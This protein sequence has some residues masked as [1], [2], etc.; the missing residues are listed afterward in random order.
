M[1]DSII[2][3]IILAIIL[4]ISI[5]L[6]E[7]AHAWASTKLGDP[8]PKLQGRLT[9]N[10][11]AHI[12]PVG[13]V[14]IFLIHFGWW[15]PVQINPSYYKNPARDEFL[16]AMAGPASN[17]IMAILGIIFLKLYVGN[18]MLLSWTSN[19]FTL[20]WMQFVFLN[21]GL[22][23]FNLLPIPP[24]DGRKIVKLFVRNAAIKLEYTLATNPLLLIIIF[25]LIW[26][27]WALWFLSSRASIV[28]S[29]LMRLINLLR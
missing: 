22:A 6:H 25:V 12:D 17:I 11:L 21:I 27:S 29:K 5:G 20:F 8:T 2:N 23:L 10:P 28:V 19:M 7:Y 24:L 13:F 26:Q 18:L 3:L 15:K 14:L 1:P 16:V 9:P 4:A